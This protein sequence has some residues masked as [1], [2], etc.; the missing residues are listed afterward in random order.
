MGFRIEF[1]TGFLN[2]RVN[3]PGILQSVY[4]RI[5]QCPSI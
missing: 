2:N 4:W 1:M 5:R 3:L